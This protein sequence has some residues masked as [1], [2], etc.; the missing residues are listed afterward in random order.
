MNLIHRVVIVI[1]QLLQWR[2]ILHRKKHHVRH[3]HII[4]IVNNILRI[5]IRRAAV[6]NKS[7]NIPM[8]ARIYSVP[9]FPNKLSRESLILR[10]Q[11]RVTQILPNVEQILVTP[12]PP[13]RFRVLQ[14]LPCVLADEAS[15][16]YGDLE[17]VPDSSLA[18]P[19]VAGRRA[20]AVGPTLVHEKL[21]LHECSVSIIRNLA[22]VTDRAPA[23][24]RIRAPARAIAARW[25]YGVV[26]AR[27]HHS[28]DVVERGRLLVVY[29][30]HSRNTERLL[31][32]RYVHDAHTRPKPSIVRRLLQLLPG[33]FGLAGFSTQLEHEDLLSVGPGFHPVL[34]DSVES[35]VY[36][37]SHELRFRVKRVHG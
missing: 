22:A 23:L 36:V 20:L 2:N 1:G 14:K 25:R 12:N 8:P 35:V 15:G 11:T 7:P 5:Q 21:S 30:V 13:I 4:V 33:E 6:I 37:S 18:N 17:L 26:P 28:L 10:I 9:A 32:P 34:L 19:V 16:R 31:F 24:S 29:S 3:L 27:I